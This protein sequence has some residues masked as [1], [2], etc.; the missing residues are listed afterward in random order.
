[1]GG[2]FWR[3]QFSECLFLHNNPF[4]AW[5][6]IKL[7][8]LDDF[9][10]LMSKIKKQNLKKHHFDTFSIEKHP[11]HDTKHTLILFLLIKKVHW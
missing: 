2:T 10:V 8:F 4:F 5:K 6:N 11:H 7:I 1:M 9:D 3:V